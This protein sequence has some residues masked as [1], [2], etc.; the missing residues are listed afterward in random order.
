MEDFPFSNDDHAIDTLSYF[1]ID[2]LPDYPFPK[3]YTNIRIAKP[4][5]AGAFN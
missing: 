1:I 5:P 3:V 2:T 4:I